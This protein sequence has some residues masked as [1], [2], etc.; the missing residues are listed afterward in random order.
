MR[1]SFDENIHLSVLYNGFINENRLRDF[2]IDVF[3]GPSACNEN[4][5]SLSLLIR[6]ACAVYY[7]SKV[8]EIDIFINA[9]NHLPVF[10]LAIAA[11]CAGKHILARITGTLELMPAKSL[12]K[13][14]KRWG[15]RKVTYLSLTLA[16][17]GICLT[18]HL[19][20]KL[21]S[22]GIPREKLVVIS[23]GVD[24]ERFKP[25]KAS[26]ILKRL[27]YV[28]RLDPLKGPQFVLE[29]YH[30][31]KRRHPELEL[32]F[33]GDGPMLDE[34]KNK[35]PLNKDG[36]TWMGNISHERLSYVYRTCDVLVLPSL[37]EGLP[38]VVLEAMASGLPVVASDV[39]DNNRLLG[40]GKRGIIVKPGSVPDIVTAIELL[41][42]ESELRMTMGHHGRQFVERNHDLSQVGKKLSELIKHTVDQGSP[43]KVPFV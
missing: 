33:C 37:S 34:L 25:N 23:Q 32:I 5:L 12:K 6:T 39:G 22:T 10:A 24:T 16:H 14:I 1:R 20:E 11:R 42:A 15:K 18:G 21:I 31:M 7:L 3:R 41:I 19:R 4:A 9:N 38:N 40:N 8:K 43:Q 28:G 30:E 35:H 13:K 26:W 29:A 36:I 17:A 2:G 27:L